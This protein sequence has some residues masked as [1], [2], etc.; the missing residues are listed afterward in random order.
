MLHQTGSIIG[1]STA[2][3]QKQMFLDEGGLLVCYTDRMTE[4]R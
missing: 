4:S 2:Y 1:E 3:T